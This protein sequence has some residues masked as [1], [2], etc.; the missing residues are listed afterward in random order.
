MNATHNDVEL[1]T[2]LSNI[3]LYIIRHGL[4]I[5][6]I[7]D[8]VG[9]V[10]TVFIFRQP[11]L[12]ANPC[13]FYLIS[14]AYANLLWILTSPFVRMLSTFGLDLSERINVL[15]KMRRS[16]AYALSSL[17]MISVALATV[18]RFLVSST[19]VGYRQL[20]SLRSAYRLVAINTIICCLIFFG[21][22]FCLNVTGTSLLEV[23][24]YTTTR[25]CG[26]YN[27]IARLVTLALIPCL[28]IL[29]F[30]FGTIRNIKKS[31]RN[32]NCE[33]RIH[34]SIR[35]TDRHL[36]QMII[37]QSLLLLISYIPNIIL[38]FYLVFTLNIDKSQ[39]RSKIETLFDDAT[40]FFTTFQSSF[41]FY[42]YATSGGQLF[43]QTL[44]AFLRSIISKFYR[45][46]RN[47]NMENIVELQRLRN[48]ISS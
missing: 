41:S 43:R 24:T 30:G 27:D 26:L 17:S 8:L 22:F 23:C 6:I 40:F 20:S 36:V 14:T 39:L 10:M 11:K 3:S 45:S 1:I 46:T 15:C 35:R 13:S 9:N 29:I 19:H 16:L 25:A 18:D 38:C 42:I 4:L 7:L 47:I 44:R 21:M 33:K 2:R 31:R 37:G 34:Q 48:H 32:I 5:M 28:L 12:R